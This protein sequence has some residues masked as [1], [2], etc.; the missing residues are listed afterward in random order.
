MGILGHYLCTVIDMDSR[1]DKLREVAKSEDDRTEDV[2]ILDP[3]SYSKVS[4][5]KR[6][7]IIQALRRNSYDS[8]KELAEDLDR[9]LK[10]VHDD[11]EILRRNSVVE[12]EQD[13]RKISP[14]LK[15]K[16]IAGERI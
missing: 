8:K 6:K 4:T 9:D 5:E 12:F 10:N 14:G 16:Y 3:E 7:E 11:L 13:G 15:H 2:L 1:V